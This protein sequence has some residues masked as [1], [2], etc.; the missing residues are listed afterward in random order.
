M[1]QFV[2]PKVQGNF[3]ENGDKRLTNGP[4]GMKMVKEKTKY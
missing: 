3:N 1:K 4:I 2:L